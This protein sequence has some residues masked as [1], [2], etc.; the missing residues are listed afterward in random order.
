MVVGYVN[1]GYRKVTFGMLLYG[2]GNSTTCPLDGRTCT[3]EQCAGET[4]TTVETLQSAD[5]AEHMT[6]QSALQRNEMSIME[7]SVLR[8]AHLREVLCVCL[9]V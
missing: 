8:A 7:P 3:K 9:L 6:L 5:D 1:R 4:Y 2:G